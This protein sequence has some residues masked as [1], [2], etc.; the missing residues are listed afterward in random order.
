MNP[1]TSTPL[2]SVIIAV[3]NG[4]ATLQ[5]CL[6]SVTQQTY[7]HIELIVIDGGSTDGTVD[8][9]QANAQQITYWISEP[10]RGIYN[11]WNKAL[12]K[13]KGDW[14][15]FLGAD[16]FLWN[17]QVLERMA[18]QLVLLPADIRVAYGQVM[19][20]DNDDQALFTL[21]KPWEQIK[22]RFKQ[23]MC[24]PHPAVMHRRSVFKEHGL[25]DESFRIAGDYELLLR[26]LRDGSAAYVPGLVVTA[27]RQGGIS[28]RPKSTLINLR[29]VRRAQ[30]KMGMRWP[31]RVWLV[32]LARVYLR[33]VLWQLLGE[34][35]TR[36][37]LDV[38]RYMMGLPAYWTKT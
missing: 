22:T 13:A 38:G 19:L 7:A 1:D 18:E 12:A 36:G 25:F 6:D 26:E 21:G 14:V 15:C 17:N 8:L 10:D 9:I 16:D 11:A 31:G 30:Q 34:K 5:Q 20:L 3:Y 24:I 32:A 2:I 27:M 23:N 28:S 4:K 35:R 37:L 29:E 33:L